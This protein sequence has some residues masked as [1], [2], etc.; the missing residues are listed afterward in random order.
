M[1]RKAR[2]TILL[3]FVCQLPELICRMPTRQSHRYDFS[4]PLGIPDTSRMSHSSSVFFAADSNNLARAMQIMRSLRQ[5]YS[6]SHL[7]ANASIART[8]LPGCQPNAYS[9]PAFPEAH[10]TRT[11]SFAVH[12]WAIVHYAII[13]ANSARLLARL[14]GV[15]LPKHPNRSEFSSSMLH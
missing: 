14:E 5:R 3:G 13:P 7:L 2:S 15:R 8:E 12:S 1:G 10:A 11:P 4:P 9:A 6:S